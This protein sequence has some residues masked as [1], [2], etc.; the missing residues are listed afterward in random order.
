MIRGL[1]SAASGMLSTIHAQEIITNNIANVNTP[2]FKRDIPV[3]E[4]FSN[5]LQRQIN[6]DTRQTRVQSTFIDLS[7]GKL[8]FTGNTFDF[9]L[10]GKGFFALSTPQGIAYTRSGNFSLDRQG[11]LV[12]PE[13]FILLGENGP[14]TISVN[15][16]SKLKFNE[17]GE[18]IIDGKVVDQIRVDVVRRSSLYKEGENLFRISQPVGVNRANNISVKVG[19][20]ETSNVDIISEMVSLINNFRM[21]EANQ[22]LIQLQ[23]STLDKA[24]NE[25]GRITR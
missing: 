5:I 14:I 8:T 21:Y 12:T 11:R 22:R 16:I 19:Y 4:S 23:D 3:Y 20:L 17:K 15:N 2:G 6:R 18:V 25:T 7:E 24:C 10:E 13:G 1:Y 9:A